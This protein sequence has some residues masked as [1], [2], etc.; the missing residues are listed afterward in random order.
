MG[1]G[2]ALGFRMGKQSSCYLL[3]TW[4]VPVPCRHCLPHGHPSVLEAPGGCVLKRILWGLAGPTLS[5][6]SPDCAVVVGSPGPHGHKSLYA[7]IRGDAPGPAQ[8]L[9][10]LALPTQPPSC[11]SWGPTFASP[12]W[13]HHKTSLQRVSGPQP[14]WELGVAPGDHICTECIVF[15]PAADDRGT[16]RPE[17]PRVFWVPQPR[18]PVTTLLLVYQACGE[19][20]A[21]LGK[22]MLSPHL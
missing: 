11:T 18:L 21:L 8:A 10:F 9:G 19:F 14:R 12:A 1:Q 3:G 2:P 20:M 17:C 13:L 6:L 15:T 5:L 4:Q 7:S 22:L 16:G